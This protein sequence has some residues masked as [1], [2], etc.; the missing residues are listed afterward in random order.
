MNHTALKRHAFNPLDLMSVA[1]A[2]KL[3]IEDARADGLEIPRGQMVDLCADQLETVSIA[4]I[5]AALVVAG[6]G[7]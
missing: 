3:C 6:V 5:R 7:Y 2:C 1:R 4:T